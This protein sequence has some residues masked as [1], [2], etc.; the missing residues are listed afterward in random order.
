MRFSATCLRLVLMGVIIGAT[1][2]SPAPTLAD[3]GRAG[4]A[5]PAGRHADPE[6]EAMLP[7][8]LGGA[9]LVVESQAGTEL[10]TRSAAFDGFLARLGRSR[11]DFTVASAYSDRGLHAEIGAWR[12]RGAAPDAMLDGLVAALQEAS[13]VP[14]SVAAETLA[15]QSVTRIGDPG[16]LARGPLWAIARDGVLLFVQTP[17]RALAE[18]AIGKLAR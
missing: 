17:D 4:A 12:V 15:G 13:R 3:T 5:I 1:V 18:E 8:V 7:R 9:A 14:L 16:Q 2:P 11:A 10:A 6:L